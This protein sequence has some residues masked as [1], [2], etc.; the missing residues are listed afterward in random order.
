ME[1]KRIHECVTDT[2]YQKTDP[3]LLILKELFSKTD[4]V[5][6]AMASVMLNRFIVPEKLV[7][8][9][10]SYLVNLSKVKK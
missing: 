5:L 9:L 3:L 2:H 6:Y 7:D 10:L 4:F 8:K 1:T